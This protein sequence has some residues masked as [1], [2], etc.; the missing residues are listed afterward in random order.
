MDR[1]RNRGLIHIAIEG[2]CKESYHF[3]SRKRLPAHRATGGRPVDRQDR[4]E[5]TGGVVEGHQ[6][7]AAGGDRVEEV[8][9]LAGGGGPPPGPPPPGPPGPGP[10][11]PPPAA[12]PR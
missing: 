3:G 5:R 7:R 6:R 4:R 11:P 8:P 1:H 12:P 9:G 2:N 10:P